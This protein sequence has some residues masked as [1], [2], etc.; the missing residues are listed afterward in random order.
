M[1]QNIDVEGR[2][3]YDNLVYSCHSCNLGKSAR[4]IPDPCLVAFGRC[5]EVDE[6]GTISAL[7]EDGQRLID[8]IGLDNE[9][10]T[11]FRSL[12]IDT[13]KSIS[14]TNTLVRWMCYP[15]DLPDL[16]PPNFTPPSGN[17]RP[18]GVDNCFYVL[19]ERGELPEIY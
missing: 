8:M 14:D 2:L 9:D 4:L 1:P 15:R 13:L 19:R 18:E 17:S 16:R 12:I 11:E 6:D 10:Y 7:N 3:D 5:L